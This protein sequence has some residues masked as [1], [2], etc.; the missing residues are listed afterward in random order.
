MSNYSELTDHELAGLLKS[1]DNIAYTEIYNR[2]HGKLYIHVFNKLHSREES[3]DILHDLFI[4][5]WQNHASLDLKTTLAAY[6]YTAARYR[7][8]D[9]VSHKQVEHKYFRSLK[10]FVDKGE[11]NTDHKV[12]ERELM[13]IIER[14]ISALPARMREIFNLSRKENLSHMQIATQLDLSEKTVKKQVN[15]ALKVLR[16]KLGFFIL[17]MLLFWM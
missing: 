14:E 15:N 10:E 16:V 3:K 4:S 7:V 6:L 13:A 11:Y 5:L 9:C 1:G 2:Y 17:M 8:F 12:R